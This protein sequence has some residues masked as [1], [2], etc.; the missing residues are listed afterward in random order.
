MT[1][2]TAMFWLQYLDM[3]SIPQRF[4]KAERMAN[5]KLPFQTV[6]DMLPYFAASGH[7]LYAKPVYVYL[8]IMLR[9]PETHPDAHRKSM[10]GY[11][12][13]RRSDRF[14]A[15]LSPDLIIEQVPMRSITTHGGLAS[16]NGMTE[17]QRSVWVLSM[18]VCA[19]INETMQQ[20][21]GVSYETSDQHNDVSAARQA[22]YVSDTVDLIDYLNERSIRSE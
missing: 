3:V 12:V 19:S 18:P 8:Q 9:L 17:N 16:G 7:S 13:V 11:H 4:I 22:R 20:F 1:T 5:W 6:Q 15:G 10:E 2:R 14:W 21:S